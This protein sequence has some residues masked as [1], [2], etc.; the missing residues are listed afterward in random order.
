MWMMNGVLPYMSGYSIEF[1]VL[2]VCVSADLAGIIT[3]DHHVTIIMCVFLPLRLL[4]V[5]NYLSAT[6]R[7]LTSLSPLFWQV[8][9]PLI[10]VY[11]SFAWIG[12]ALFGGL[13]YEG[14]PLLKGTGYDNSSY[15]IFNWNDL[16]SALVSQF[17]LLVGNN[18]FVIVDGVVAITGKLCVFFFL[19]YSHSVL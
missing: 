6:I 16:P 13:L 9:P 18:A 17:A 12:I 8:V 15:W 14:N 11:Y 10:S 5:T 7:S 1:F 2:L 4:G 3:T 19:Y